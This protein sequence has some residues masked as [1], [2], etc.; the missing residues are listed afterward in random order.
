MF[1]HPLLILQIT[2]TM[3]PLY[4]NYDLIIQV[5]VIWTCLR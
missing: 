4:E 2:K 1:S 3:G 5:V